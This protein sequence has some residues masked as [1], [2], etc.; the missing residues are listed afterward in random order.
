MQ[1]VKEKVVDIKSVFGTQLF[2]IGFLC[3]A[4][5][6]IQPHDLDILILIAFLRGII[7]C[8]G[9]YLNKV[10]YTTFLPNRQVR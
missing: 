6:G 1:D 10:T 2:R 3:F 7:S 5:L 9:N 4:V 8:Y